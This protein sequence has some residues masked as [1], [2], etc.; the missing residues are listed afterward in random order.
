ML[1]KTDEQQDK[2]LAKHICDLFTRLSQR[3]HQALL[4]ERVHNQQFLARY[5]RYARLTCKPRIPDSTESVIVQGYL[6]MRAMGASRNIISATPR[7]LEA[8]VRISEALAKM[9]LSEVVEDDDAAEAIKL[10]KAATR[11]SAMDPITGQIDINM[12][13]TGFSSLHEEKRQEIER[14]V[15]ELMVRL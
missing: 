7:H 14:I 2:R 5:I 15:T 1:D 8:I 9:R 6:D 12:I 3:E 13:A 4:A 10:V 11:Q